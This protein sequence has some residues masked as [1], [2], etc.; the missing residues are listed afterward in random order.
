MKVKTTFP[1]GRLGTNVHFESKVIINSPISGVWIYYYIY[2]CLFEGETLQ[3]F[4]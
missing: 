4:F 2:L 3:K 1:V